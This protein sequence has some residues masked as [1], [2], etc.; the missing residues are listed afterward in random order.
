MQLFHLQDLALGIGGFAK[1]IDV[2]AW[3]IE[4]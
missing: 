2:K 3:V 4:N 1:L